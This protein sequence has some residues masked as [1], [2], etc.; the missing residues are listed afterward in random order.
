[1]DAIVFATTV[2]RC[3]R[4]GWTG[5]P[6][7]NLRACPK[8]SGDMEQKEIFGNQEAAFPLK[9]DMRY[10][11]TRTG[12]WDHDHCLICD[13]AIGRDTHWGYRESSFAGGPNSVGIWLCERCFN[14]YLK[15]GDFSF[16]VGSSAADET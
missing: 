10:V 5:G 12:L 2:L 14:R 15:R 3:R 8:C 6:A 7:S 9:A 1:T 11:E 4:C 16:L 13:V